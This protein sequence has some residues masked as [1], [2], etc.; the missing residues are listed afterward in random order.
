MSK[1]LFKFFAAFAQYMMD[2]RSAIIILML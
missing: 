1:L 2:M